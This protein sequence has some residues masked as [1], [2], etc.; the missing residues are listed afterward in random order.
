MASKI[1]LIPSDI[2][3]GLLLKADTLR[4]ISETYTYKV[5]VCF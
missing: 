3:V 1:K 5:F 4:L 2:S